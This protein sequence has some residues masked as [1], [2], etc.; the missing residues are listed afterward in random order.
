MKTD[1]FEILLDDDAK[2]ITLAIIKS[3]GLAFKTYDMFK[4]I[5]KDNGTVI[6][7]KSNRR[8]KIYS[9]EEFYSNGK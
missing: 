5:Y 7:K 8:L 9:Q 6:I 2:V 1:I 4:E 3:K